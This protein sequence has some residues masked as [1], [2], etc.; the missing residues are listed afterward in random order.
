[1]DSIAGIARIL[2]IRAGYSGF[3]ISLHRSAR[4]LFNRSDIRSRVVLLPERLGCIPL[5]GAFV[6]YAEPWLRDASSHFCVYH[7]D[8]PLSLDA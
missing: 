3:T 6:C 8:G 5:H 7:D 1:V 2:A 4:R